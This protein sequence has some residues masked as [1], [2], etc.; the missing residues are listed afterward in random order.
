MKTMQ[1]WVGARGRREVNISDDASWQ[2]EASNASVAE[3]VKVRRIACDRSHRRFVEIDP[4]FAEA[5]L[6]PVGVDV[7]VGPIAGSTDR[8]DHVRVTDRS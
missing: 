2:A 7:S 8:R 5:T 1:R 4:G 3:E 6:P